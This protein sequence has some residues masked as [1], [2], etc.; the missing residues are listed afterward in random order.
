MKLMSIAIQNF[1]G[2]QTGNFVFPFNQRIIGIIGPGDSCKTTLLKAIEWSLWPTWNLSATDM[3][4][5][6]GNTS[7]PIIIESTIAEIPSELLSE[8][9]F[10]LYL[11]DFEA[12]IRGAENDE[13]VEGKIPV[14]TIRLTIDDT[15][16]PA[17]MVITNRTDPRP[18]S[19]KDR[20][21]FSFGVVGFN[22]DKDFLWGRGSILQKYSGAT[23]GT[24]HTAYTQ[25][26]RLAIENT[27]LTTLD[28]VTKEVTDIG[29]QYGVSFLGKLNNKLIMQN[30]SYSTAVGVFDDKIPFSQRGLGSKRLLSIGLNIRA[31]LEG[32]L[33]LVDEIETGLEPYRVCTLINQLRS[34]FADKGQ[35][36][37]TTHSRSVVCECTVDELF[38]I[39]ENNGEVNLFPLS[40]QETKDEV[41]AIIRREPESF[42][43]KRLIVC[44]GKTEIGI[45][46]ALDKHIFETRGSRF[47]HYGVGTTLGE[48]GGTTFKLA[49]LL[50]NC[51]Y[52]VSILL[53]AD[54]DSETNE[55]K[56]MESLGIKVFSWESGNAIEEQL[57]KDVDLVTAEELI[58]VA[59]EDKSF[60]HV[61][62][63]LDSGFEQDSKPYFKDGEK[64]RLFEIISADERRHIGTIAKKDKCGWFKRID[65]GEKVGEILFS[66]YDE[67]N[68]TAGLKVTIEQLKRWVMGDES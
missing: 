4:F 65:L 62:T 5:Y 63:K 7:N 2:V 39:V 61:I 48:G 41:Q 68:D 11:R 49:K 67:I 22:Y 59:C 32:S 50:K 54:V 16:E 64:I 42:L 20:R 57:F 33:I 15:L 12:V 1:R 53:D 43:C 45:L 17:W 46:R 51:G 55:K 37:F 30:G 31:S 40:E 38:V 58:S 26:M 3:D 9:K 10:G 28:F 24:L 44:E 27:D 18:I 66:K 34:E 35:L 52:D 36:I 29:S 19:Q 21:L 25:A 13:P 6:N 47:S 56:N 14:I 23:R 60:D 8:D